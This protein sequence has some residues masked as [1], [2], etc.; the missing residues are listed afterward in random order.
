[1]SHILGIG[2]GSLR[3]V[4]LRPE[5]RCRKASLFGE[6]GGAQS[7]RCEF[8]KHL[9]SLCHVKAGGIDTPGGSLTVSTRFLPNMNPH[10]P[11]SKRNWGQEEGL[12][13]RATIEGKQISQG[14][15]ASPKAVLPFLTQKYPRNVQGPPSSLSPRLTHQ[16]VE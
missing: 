4:Q 16:Q 13:G 12:S 10:M 11:T 14:G 1:M 2:Q 7:P 5:N 3:N 9:L 6:E 15:S 8:I